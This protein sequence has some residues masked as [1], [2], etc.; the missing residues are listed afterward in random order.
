M[1]DERLHYPTL[2]QDALKGMV[3]SALEEVQEEG[4]PGEH[5]FYLHFAT[6][7]PDV[8]MPAFL[9]E[10]HPEEMVII[11]QHQYW[12]LYVDEDSFSVTLSFGG[13]RHSLSVPFSALTGFADPS[14]KFALKFE[15]AGLSEL[16]VPEEPSEEASEREPRELDEGA[17]ANV[18][19][20][21][22]FRNR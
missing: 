14:V 20:F 17:Q 10:Q 19:D 7:H 13:Q 6:G 2:I 18:V 16:V 4:F 12:D 11:L 8:E 21:E 1:N 9:R 5:H 3:R 15:V 22:A